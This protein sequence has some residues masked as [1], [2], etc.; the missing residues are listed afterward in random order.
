MRRKND[1]NAKIFGH[2]EFLALENPL[3]FGNGVMG[4][5]GAVI[6]QEDGSY[7]PNLKANKTQPI[8]DNKYCDIV[9]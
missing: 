6:Q 4:S 5:K 2:K 3:I 9:A 7:K 1:P 8:D